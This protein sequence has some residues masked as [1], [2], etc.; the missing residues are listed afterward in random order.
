MINQTFSELESK[1]QASGLDAAKQRELLDLLARLKSEIGEQQQHNLKPLKSPVED[2]RSS[3]EGFEQSHPK[4]V[5]AVNKVSQT[6]ADL[7]I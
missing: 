4:L 3:V 1:I 2:L 7:G 5:Q 6:L